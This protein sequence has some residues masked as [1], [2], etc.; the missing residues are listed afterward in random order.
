MLARRLA[1]HQEDPDEDGIVVLHGATWADFERLL[2][3]RGEKSAPRFAFLEGELEIMSPSR[4]HEGIKGTMG[5][6]VETF[7][8]ARGIE[9]KRYGSW[10][11][12]KSKKER[13]VEPDECYVFGEAKNPRR[14]HLAIEVIWTSGGPDKLD[15]YRYLGVREVW[16]WREGSI[17]AHALRDLNYEAIKASEVLPGI[18]IEKIAELVERPT[19]S[20]AIRE[21]Q[22]FLAKPVKKPPRRRARK[23]RHR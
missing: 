6:L 13:G 14:P 23:A 19:D 22:A 9:W 17:T 1:D 10:T 11:L 4:S 12:K 15:I 16:I 20:Q 2:K 5:C 3:L 8:L 7:C 18:D 21:F